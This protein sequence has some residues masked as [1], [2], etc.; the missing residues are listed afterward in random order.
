MDTTEHTELGNELAIANLNNNPYLRIDERGTLHIRLQRL[1]EN[2]L[3]T[4]MDLE[5]SA[6]EIIAMAGDFFTDANWTV[7]LELP[8]CGLF[9]N[10]TRLGK[11][12]INTPVRQK[13]EDALIRAYNN[14]AA[15]NVTRKEIDC[16]YSISNANYLPFSDTLNFY[17]KQ[18]M[19][20]FRVKNY[21]EMITRNQT[22]FTPW[23]IRVYVLGHTIALR[24]A[25]LAYELRQAA[26]NALY[27]SKNPDFLSIKQ[28]HKNKNE[29]LSSSKLRDLADR[30]EALAY[31]MELFTFHYYSDHF[32]TGHMSMIGDLRVVLKERFGTW[33]NILANNLHDEVNQV[34]VYTI[35]P[36][37]ENPNP[38]QPPTRSR[39]DGKVDTCLNKFNRLG[40]LTGMSASINDV[41]SVLKGGDT[42]QQKK[43]AGLNHLPDVDYN[44]R[45]H[46]PLLVFSKG[47]VYHRK[48]LSKIN[49][50]SPSEYEALRDNPKSHG[51]SELK[52]SWDAFVL[53]CKLRLLPCLYTG[54]I[55]PI[56]DARLTEI[57]ADEK[58]RNPE[59]EPIQPPGCPFE[60][61]ATLFSWKSPLATRP[62]KNM[63]DTMDGL[64][65]YSFLKSKTQ[66]AS[67][68]NL[69]NDNT[70][71]LGI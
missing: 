35:N 48:E 1:D 41:Q 59:R 47:K 39:G 45:Q 10:T 25:R 24:Y 50:L 31:C 19:F 18:L 38:T 42:P 15:P 3:P 62:N 69:D 56:D 44:L 26:D 65:N 70:V 29:E 4:P 43:Y 13:E 20:Y 27:E 2:K 12:L 16:I 9:E 11:H 30:Y 34:G 71:R 63:L 36:Y 68:E 51:Y 32:A 37:G 40:C 53:V 14:L 66:T 6:G 57:L 60:K 52:S 22:H 58:N 23:S 55:K 28:L 33:G 54:S 46:Q 7:D 64:K 8:K 5:L 17:A 67:G 49:I 21:G 61:E